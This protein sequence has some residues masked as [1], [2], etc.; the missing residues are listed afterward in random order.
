MRGEVA[1]ALGRAVAHDAIAADIAG[2]TAEREAGIVLPGT[3][4]VGIV[5]QALLGTLRNMAV[6]GARATARAIA[7]SGASLALLAA[8]QTQVGMAV[9]ARANCGRSR[10]RRR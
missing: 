3:A 1:I 2:R 8:T 9:A 5:P 6:T 4:I 7:V 10:P